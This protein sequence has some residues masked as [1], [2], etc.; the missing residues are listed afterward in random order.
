M[1]ASLLSSL[2]NVLESQA[3]V[4]AVPSHCCQA[5]IA[6]FRDLVLQTVNVIF[7]YF[8]KILLHKK[9]TSKEAGSR[10]EIW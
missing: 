2:L 8:V 9:Y 3:Y 7:I 10:K 4:P 1:W 6:P 5:V